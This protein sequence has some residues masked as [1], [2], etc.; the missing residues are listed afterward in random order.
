MK[1]LAVATTLVLALVLIPDDPESTGGMPR[2]PQLSPEQQIFH[3]VLEGL[4]TDGVRNETV[5][6]ILRKGK[7]GDYVHF[8]RGCPL[9]N[10]TLDAVLHYRQRP[11]FANRKSRCDTFGPGLSKELRAR[12]ASPDQK[13]RLDVVHTLITR[14]MGRR[15][16]QLRLTD[17]ER[18]GWEIDMAK[19]RKKGMAILRATRASGQ[20]EE[21]GAITDC[22]ICDGSNDALR[23][24]TKKKVGGKK[25]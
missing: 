21:W 14:W 16:A 12:L 7:A 9:C 1:I 8:V 17:E 22:A 11:E 2:V 19:R 15:V 6:L 24:V 25:K 13:T 10:P 23:P 18:R 3:G 4:Y 5:D 20:M